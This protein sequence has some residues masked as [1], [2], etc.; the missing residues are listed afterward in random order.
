M[1]QMEEANVRD[2]VKME[3]ISGPDNNIENFR[4]INDVLSEITNMTWGG[5]R[6]RF[7]VDE[8]YL[9]ERTT[10][11]P[12]IVNHKNKYI[13]FGINT[14]QLCFK[15]TLKERSGNQKSFTLYHKFCFNLYWKPD[16]FCENQ[17]SV[18]DLVSA[19]DLEFF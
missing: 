5:I 6:N 13:T 4:I 14:P 11:V 8:N 16:K 17:P 7:V 3:K 1:L 18:N 9:S 2:M 15:Y 12:I 10:Q 19:G